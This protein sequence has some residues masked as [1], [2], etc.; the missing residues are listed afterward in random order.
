MQK[1]L[2][3]RLS[4]DR[5]VTA[6]MILIALL[7]IGWIAYL[8][9]PLALEPKGEA[10]PRLA[11]WIPFPNATAAQIL[12]EIVIPLEDAVSTLSGFKGTKAFAQRDRG[13][14]Y[15]DYYKGTDMD[16]AWSDLLDRMDRYYAQLDFDSTLKRREIDIDWVDTG[17]ENF[18]VMWI[19]ALFDR[20]ITRPGVLLEETIKP[21]M[22]HIDGVASV[23]IWTGP[24]PVLLVRLDED[25]IRSL[26]VDIDEV[27][28][29]ITEDNF[30]LSSGRISEGGRR[31][32]VRSV[33]NLNSVEQYR[34]LLVDPVHGLRL[35]DI[36]DVQLSKTAGIRFNRINRQE[37][38]W[39]GIRR[40]PEG[41]VVAISTA[42]RRKL[43]D[44]VDDPRLAAAD[45]KIVWD[46]AEH[47]TA[48]I[49]NLKVSGLWG[50]LFA[51]IVL[52]LFL[53]NLRMTLI[54]TS[55]I[56]LSILASMTAIYFYGWSLNLA[57]MMGLMLSLGLVVDNAI[58]VVENIYRKRSE[59]LSG[60]DASIDGAG[61]VGL[62]ITMA[63]LTTVVVFLPLILM[64]DDDFFSFWMWRVGMP[65]TAGLFTS[66]VVALLLFPLAAQRFSSRGAQ[67]ERQ[68]IQK[69]QR[70]YATSLRWI[71]S[72]RVDAL[73][74]LLLVGASVWIPYEGV[75]Q[76]DQ[77]SKRRSYAWMK[78][79]MP[80]GYSLE[81][82]NEFMTAVEDTLMNQRERYN[83][84]RVRI[85]YY[86][87]FGGSASINLKKEERQEWYQVLWNG[88]LDQL[89]LVEK[90]RLDYD[91]MIADLRQRLPSRPGIFLSINGE[92]GEEDASLTLN[93]YGKD[94]L[95]LTK[96]AR[97]V[98]RRLLD[99]PGFVAVHTDLDRGSSEIQIRL[100]QKKMQRYGIQPRSISNA[101]GMRWPIGAIPENEV[102]ITRIGDY[103]EIYVKVRLED[104]D[105]QDLQQLRNLLFKTN[106]GID[107]PLDAF[108]SFHVE[109]SLDKITRF[110]R[111]AMVA[112]T[113]Y[114][115][116][117]DA[118]RL[119]DKVDTA[120]EGL[121][122]PRG[123]RW[124]KG[125][126]F[127]RMEETDRSQQ[128]AIMLSITFVFLLMGVLFE[129]FVLPLSVIVSIPFAGLGVY[130]TLYATGT[131]MDDMSRMGT[132]ILVGVVVNNAI[133]LVDLVNRLRHDGMERFEALVE[134]GRHRFR[135]ILMTTFTT[136]FGLIPM[137]VGNPN[138]VGT[139]YAPMGRTMMGGLLASMVLTLLVVPLCYTFF[140]DLR[141]VVG[142]AIRSG[143]NRLTS[144]SGARQ[145]LPT[146][147]G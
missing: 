146:P 124:D 139:D 132:V 60:R 46:Q 137:A 5:P 18:N 98:Q 81:Q 86:Y 116:Q 115:T 40:T 113:A 6:V 72:H 131:P 71:L 75:Q 55:A 63:T 114:A 32:L 77:A 7:V 3:P 20:S 11:V 109:H 25:R 38:I 94:Y 96:M 102:D 13:S 41:N 95:V 35:R 34:E 123:Y 16:R 27:L 101:I 1:Y 43:R 121:E 129:S 49:H 88:M 80:R 79:D 136:I 47:I 120:M 22:M 117:E 4:V 8:R 29:R 61:E 130:W 45:L 10:E 89:G 107:M 24:D 28:Q 17:D 39:I 65:V 64:T 142:Q 93:I 52:M 99:I 48:S 110:N 69:L 127:I 138:V 31:L 74:L 15:V 50:G 58:V 145:G 90:K 44:F 57:T 56:P 26:G 141:E 33:A 62:A 106:D 85:S 14:S 53:R 68:A 70:R 66:L 23:E 100:D 67:R 134:A 87:G 59:G 125:A 105:G 128:F 9:I 111:Q 126:R 12:E 42:A 135:P 104:E 103:R 108:A 36:A 21:A 92:Q 76:T 112:V 83:A 84:D 143:A 122:M 73:L 37:S 82:L 30:A 133:V 118:K 140:D 119:F 78:F 144:P 54:I 19:N 51:G 97:E 2:L 91:E 147:P